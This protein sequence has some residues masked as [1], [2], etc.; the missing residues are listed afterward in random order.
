MLKIL[1]LDGLDADLVERWNLDHLLQRYH[2]RLEV[3]ISKRYGHPHSPDVWA[4][5]LTGEWY[6]DLRFV[7]PYGLHRFLDF[8]YWMRGKLGTSLGLG[9]IGAYIYDHTVNQFPPLDVPLVNGYNVPF[10]NYDGASLKVLQ[11]YLRDDVSAQETVALLEHVLMG[12]FL[13]LVFMD[14]NH[15][16]PDVVFL[17]FPDVVQHFCLDEARDVKPIYRLLNDYV[18]R[19]DT[20]PLIVSDHGHMFATGMHSHHGFWSFSRELDPVPEKI[21][22]F[23]TEY[24]SLWS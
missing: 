13:D 11:R 14:V 22:D 16:V 18:G 1:C 15:E 20:N 10:I 2:G 5:F 23:R 17:E 21:T 7:R 9:R 19:L 6:D 8:M 4:S 3:P 12:R 24:P